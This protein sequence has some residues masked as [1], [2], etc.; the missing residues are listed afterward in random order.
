MG[1]SRTPLPWMA[2]GN[3]VRSQLSAEVHRHCS[4]REVEAP[5]LARTRAS[6]LFSRLSFSVHVIDQGRASQ[7]LSVVGKVLMDAG[8]GCCVRGTAYAMTS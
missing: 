5:R 7:R 4:G 8:S 3:G 1:S 6:M 2:R